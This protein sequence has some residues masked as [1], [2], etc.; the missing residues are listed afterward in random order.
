MD[1]RQSDSLKFPES[2]RYSDEHIW[3]ELVDEG[4]IRC[5]VTEY[6]CEK[7]EEIITVEFVKNI[8]NMELFSGEAVLEVESLKDS[9]VIK[10]PASGIVIEINDLCV[11]TP[12]IINNDPYGEGWLFLIVCNNFYEYEDL[13]HSDEYEYLV[14]KEKENM[15]F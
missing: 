2:Y 14:I 5:G 11:E 9:I 3:M 13:M 7:T 10:T 6:F 12:E 1:E 8:I 4:N 15:Y